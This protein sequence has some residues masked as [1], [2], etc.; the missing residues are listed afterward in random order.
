MMNNI[1][2]SVIM[3]TYNHAPYVEE[4]MRS[5]LAQQGVSFEFL[6]AD[7]GSKDG[8]ANAVQK[9]SDPRIQFTPHAVNRGACVTTN[10]LIHRAKGRYVALINS[11][12]RWVGNDKLLKQMRLLDANP[13]IGAS[14]GRA[15]FIDHAGNPIPKKE[16]QTGS[17]FDKENRSR[18]KWLRYFFDNGNC[19]LHPSLL[20][21]KSC[22]DELGVYDNRYRQLPDFDM[23]IRL[24]K[25]HDIHIADENYV[26]F[27]ILPGENASSQTLGNSIRTINEHY[28][29]A[30]HFFDGVLA[31][32]FVDG[33]ADQCDGRFDQPE[34]AKIEAALML[35]GTKGTY[36]AD[37]ENPYKVAALEKIF[38][39]LADER[40]RE[41][42]RERYGIDDLWFQKRAAEVACL[43]FRVDAN[44]L[45]GS[46][47]QAKPERKHRKIKR[48]L[49]KIFN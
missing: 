5:V 21:R 31:D 30:R 3:S 25:R 40:A 13:S 15:T 37:L 43:R 46:Q 41:L 33:F 45:H 39:L 7:D 22:Y 34:C 18:G 11:D 38:D 35:M 23:W 19:L 36:S 24:I 4:A 49:K 16:L 10:E 2:V 47:A 12:D 42:L 1:D 6:I 17:V 9:I 20:I 44:S 27:R 29:I 32:D 26:E 14:F 48:M 8:T 28:L